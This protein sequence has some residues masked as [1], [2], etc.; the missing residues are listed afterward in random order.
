MRGPVTLWVG[1]TNYSKINRALEVPEMCAAPYRVPFTSPD[2]GCRLLLD[3]G[4]FPDVKKGRLTFQQALDRQL[5][6]E[7]RSNIV[8]ERI[9]SYDMLIDEKL[10]NG[11]Q[12][13]ERWDEGPAWHAVETTIEAARFLTS[14]R[15]ELQPRQLVLSCQGVTV[16]QYVE[17]TKAILE[18]S[19]PEDIIG[20]GGW[21]ILGRKRAMITQFVDTIREVLP[22]VKHAGISHVHLFGVGWLVGLYYY[23]K[24]LEE[25]ELKGGTDTTRFYNELSHGYLFDPSTGKSPQTS[26][27]SLYTPDVAVKNIHTA[28]DYISKLPYVVPDA[29]RSHKHRVNER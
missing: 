8:S 14:K 13:K 5:D 20:L 2:V 4:A 6:Y 17:C 15:E 21:C 18:F 22:L 28:Y 26:G 24:V 25:L 11:V 9:V 23:A 7:V 27:R 19:N 16:K 1:N 10:V 12:V 3:S 29:L